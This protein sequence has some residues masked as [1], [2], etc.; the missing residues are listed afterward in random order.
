MKP[1]ALPQ[2]EPEP[3]TLPLQEKYPQSEDRQAT[4]AMTV[5]SYFFW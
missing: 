2:P 4:W 5:L 1:A 3:A